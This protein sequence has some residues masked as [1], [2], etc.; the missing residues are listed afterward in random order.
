VGR[1]RL[2]A[3]ARSKRVPSWLPHVVIPGLVA[4]AL[5]PIERRRILL[6]APLVWVPD[7]DYIIPEQHRAVTHTV[8]IPIAIFAGLLWLWRRR[9]PSARFGEYS[10]RPGAP[11]NL[12]LASYYIGSHLFLDIFAG[13]VV[14]FWP[15]LNTNFYYLFEIYLDT[16]NNTFT[17]YQEGGTESGAPALAPIYRWVSA[18]D[19]AIVAFLALV[20]AVWLLIWLRRPPGPVVVER[21]AM[22]APSQAPSEKGK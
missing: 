17:P 4:L 7:L 21:A 13:G 16:S 14:L 5:F 11:A 10:T 2:N 6:L 22:L 15:V 18:V 8:W 1:K 3:A 20:A 12:T 19:T 9:D